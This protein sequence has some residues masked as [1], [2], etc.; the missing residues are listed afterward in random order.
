VIYVLWQWIVLGSVPLPQLVNAWEQGL[1]A[2]ASLSKVAISSWIGVGAKFFS[3]FAIVTSFLGVSLSLSDFLT[4]GLKIKKSWE[5]R[6]LAIGL[7]FVPPLI[8]I[9]TYQK[10]FYIALEYAG[11]FVAILLGIL[12]SLMVLRL[13]S[14]PFYRKKRVKCLVF[15]VIL[16][17]LGVIAI[18]CLEK[19]GYLERFITPYLT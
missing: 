6:L 17:S 2:T 12:P 19:M 18:N 11:V 10:S 5:G 13:K 9:F 1:P 14:H 3:F 7:T 16:L 8:F 4:D 15:F